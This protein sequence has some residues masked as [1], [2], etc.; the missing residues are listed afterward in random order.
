[1]ER[2]FFAVKAI[3]VRDEKF[4]ALYDYKK[5]NKR[6]DLPGGRMEF[7]ET[8]EETLKREVREELSLDVRPIKVIDTWNLT[9]KK[10]QITGIFYLVDMLTDNIKISEEHEDYEWILIK[11]IGRYFAKN[12]Y[13]SRM[14]FW[15]WDL[16]LDQSIN[17]RS[18]IS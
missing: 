16:I 9:H 7:G 13:A 18:D 5:G 6:W 8:A 15:N 4:L 17:F 12:I 3:I 11:D 10:I 2:F 14:E 1:M